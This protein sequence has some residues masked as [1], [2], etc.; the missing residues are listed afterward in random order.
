MA[1][2]LARTHA[3]LSLGAARL[4]KGHVKSATF[5]EEASLAPIFP[6]V[7]SGPLGNTYCDFGNQ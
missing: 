2:D 1:E 6:P 7:G 4:N 5:A 3:W